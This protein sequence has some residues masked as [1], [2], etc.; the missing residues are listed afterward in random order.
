MIMDTIIYFYDYE[1][2]RSGLWQ[3]N[4]FI[5]MNTI[6]Y[7]YDHGYDKIYLLLWIQ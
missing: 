7:I 1:Y 4:Y 2:T 6:K 3:Q 5:D